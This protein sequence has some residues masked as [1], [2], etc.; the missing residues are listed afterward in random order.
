M[1]GGKVATNFIQLPNSSCSWPLRGRICARWVVWV[2]NA[3]SQRP[4]T[5]DPAE[6]VKR[7]KSFTEPSLQL[8]CRELEK[9]NG[10]GDPFYRGAGER[11]WRRDEPRTERIL[12]EAVVVTSTSPPGLT[13][14]HSSPTANPGSE[15]T[16]GEMLNPLPLRFQS[17]S[18]LPPP[19][20]SM[21]G[22]V[23]TKLS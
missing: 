14:D 22:C 21:P 8:G 2:S 19:S 11:R 4:P 20:L 13:A 10:P 16:Y 9:W 3:A 5:E 7:R 6:D 15:R 18:A 23:L 17:P 12:Q 1:T